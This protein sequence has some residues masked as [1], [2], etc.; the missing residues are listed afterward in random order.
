MFHTPLTLCCGRGQGP[1][2]QTYRH[3]K[4]HWRAEVFRPLRSILVGIYVVLS[5]LG[6][7]V[8]GGAVKTMP[9]VLFGAYFGWLYLRIWQVKGEAGLKCAAG[10]LGFFCH[11][12]WA[13]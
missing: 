2:L 1:A 7:L 4:D 6:C 9:S 3:A 8:L 10:S 12:G 11:G 13:P 5:L